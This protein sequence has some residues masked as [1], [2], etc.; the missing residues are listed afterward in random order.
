MNPDDENFQQDR[1]PQGVHGQGGEKTS[2]KAQRGH[3]GGTAATERARP[4]S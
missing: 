3:K 2:G 4:G 1:K